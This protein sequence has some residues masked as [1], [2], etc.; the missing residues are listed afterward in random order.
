MYKAHTIHKLSMIIQ[1][2]FFSKIVLN[3][4]TL[5]DINTMPLNTGKAFFVRQN[6]YNNV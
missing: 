5:H 4:I 2:N 3:L 6:Y 1:R